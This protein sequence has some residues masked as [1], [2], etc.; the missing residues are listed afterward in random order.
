M[1]RAGRHQPR[2]TDVLRACQAEDR[3]PG[4]RPQHAGDGFRPI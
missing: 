2:V 3:V 4:R 1:A